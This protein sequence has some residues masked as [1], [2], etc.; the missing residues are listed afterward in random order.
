MKYPAVD[1]YFIS[2]FFLVSLAVVYLVVITLTDR[3]DMTS[4]M[5]IICATILFLTGILLF[6]FSKR[7]SLDEQVVSMLSVQGTINLC[8]IAADL[9]IAGSACFLPAIRI[10]HPGVM[11]FMPVTSYDGGTLSGD[12]F[13]SG[14][15]GIGILVPPSGEALLAHLKRNNQIFIPDNRDAIS[16]LIGEIADDLLEIA[17]SARVAWSDD[18]VSILVDGFRLASG[19]RLISRESPACCTMNPCPFCSLL[20]ACIVEGLGHPVRID[21]CSPEMNRDTVQI[22]FTILP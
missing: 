18:T 1:Q 8:R 20:A 2:S 14:P 10:G 6:T 3:K 12:S 5:V 16:L 17:D 13:V 4:A 22:W 21:R 7:E 19:C 15:G 11:Q 9:G